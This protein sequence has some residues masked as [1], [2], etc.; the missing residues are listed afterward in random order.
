MDK[1]RYDVIII[2]A[3]PGGLT[4]AMY[5]ARAGLTPLVLERGGP[6]GQM[7]ATELIENYPGFPDNVTGTELAE[8]LVEHAKR[9]GA[10][11]AYGD[12]KEFCARGEDNAICVQTAAGEQLTCR[13]LVLATGA[14]PRKVGFKG[15]E[16]FIGRG[17]SYCALCDGNFYRGR[18]VCVVGGG[19]SAVEEAVYLSNIAKSITVIHR[20]EQL[21]AKKV[22]QDA[23]MARDNISFR[24]NSEVEEVFGT[25]FVEGVRVKNNKT[26][27]QSEIPCDGIFFYVGI[28]P[29][30]S[31]VPDF[32]E[33]DELGFIKTDMKM[34][35]S[36][37][38][39]YAVGDVRR[40]MGR[41]VA[42]AVGDGADAAI[43]IQHYLLEYPW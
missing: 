17:V 43:A 33:R 23:A 1:S 39:I 34:Q 8:K 2:G 14:A 21:R 3:G 37:P 35:T 42:T 12:V 15:E 40:P 24:W 22:A 7:L 41:Q 18:D 10:E 36:S 31:F 4:C 26:G 9:W 5:I 29:A 16:E 32:I 27:E 30:T 11:V 38:G 20:R 28:V 19:D 6:G 25:Q 13:A